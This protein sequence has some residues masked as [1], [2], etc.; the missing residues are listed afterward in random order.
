[1][2]TNQPFVTS[3]ETY[4]KVVEIEAAFYQSATDNRPVTIEAS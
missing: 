4:L 1:M 2:L 3:G